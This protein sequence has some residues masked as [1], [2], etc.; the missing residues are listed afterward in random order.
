M[1]ITL[2]NG[3]QV[4]PPLNVDCRHTGLHHAVV[5]WEHCD[6]VVVVAK[7]DQQKTTHR[8]NAQDQPTEKNTGSEREGNAREQ[9]QECCLC[10]SSVSKP[11]V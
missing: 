1:R 7:C 2:Y 9:L 3:N 4:D 10:T 8:G 5:H 11:S 6:E